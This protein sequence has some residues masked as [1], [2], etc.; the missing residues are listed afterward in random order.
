[1]T[2]SSTNE[3]LFVAELYVQV[4]V[5]WLGFV[6]VVKC[7]N[8]VATTTRHCDTTNADYRSIGPLIGLQVQNL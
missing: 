8:P 3:R 7:Q 5:Y 4:A 6:S 2:W 1:M